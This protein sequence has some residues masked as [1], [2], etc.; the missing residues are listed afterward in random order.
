MRPTEDARTLLDTLVSLQRR[1]LKTA[2][3]AA[4]IDAVEGFREVAAAAGATEG[5][6]SR[7]PQGAGR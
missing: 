2:F 3:T 5:A 4:G 6:R 7:R 1:L